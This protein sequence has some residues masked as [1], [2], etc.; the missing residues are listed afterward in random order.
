MHKKT[1]KLIRMSLALLV[2]AP[3]GYSA[4]NSNTSTASNI[5]AT[6]DPVSDFWINKYPQLNNIQQ[7]MPA[8]NYKVSPSQ[9]PLVGPITNSLGIRDDILK[10]VLET[11]PASNESALYH[12][13]KYTQ[14]GQAMFL[15]T[16][17]DQANQNMQ[18]MMSSI[19]CLDKSYGMINT[20][21]LILKTVK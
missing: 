19:S 14:Y 8:D 4:I 5:S 9:K 10:N 21:N 20:H 1:L 2:I 17:K 15:A 16:D 11:I 6:G 3:C 7:K 12:A 13:I 18:N